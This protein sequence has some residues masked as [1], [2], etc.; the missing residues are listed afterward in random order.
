[1]VGDDGGNIVYP[2]CFLIY[3]VFGIS[4]R[5]KFRVNH[6]FH[7]LKSTENEHS[8]SFLNEN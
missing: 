3:R 7:D 5:R 4:E 2:F 8:F 1:M 6:D